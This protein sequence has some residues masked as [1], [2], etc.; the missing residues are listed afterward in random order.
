[1]GTYI[2]FSI[3][4]GPCTI[5]FRNGDIFSGNING[6]WGD[7]DEDTLFIINGGRYNDI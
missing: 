6:N 2:C 4:K 5:S 1:M 7:I 3:A